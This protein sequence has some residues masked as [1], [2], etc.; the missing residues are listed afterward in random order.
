M[1]WDNTGGGASLDWDDGGAAVAA[2][3]TFGNGDGL[4]V[5]TTADTFNGGGGGGGAGG[6]GGFSGGCF[7]WWITYQSN[8]H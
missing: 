5:G 7:N 6:G 8:L 3:N 2:V 1:S 4:A